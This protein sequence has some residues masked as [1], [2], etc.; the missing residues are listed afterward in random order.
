MMPLSLELLQRVGIVG[1][2][3]RLA[4]RV[5]FR[6]FQPSHERTF[7]VVEPSWR[8]KESTAPSGIA[9]LTLSMLGV[10][11]KSWRPGR[12]EGRTETGMRRWWIETMK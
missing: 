9:W 1:E 4:A 3:G 5:D 7:Q 11:Q 12:K 6:I 8:D 10:V 2:H